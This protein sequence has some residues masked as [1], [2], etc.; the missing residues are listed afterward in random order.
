MQLKINSERGVFLNFANRSNR[1]SRLF[2]L[3]VL[4][5]FATRANAEVTLIDHDG[6]QKT[7]KQHSAESAAC[8]A[9]AL[10]TDPK[11]EGKVTIKFDVSDNGSVSAPHYESDKTTVKNS[12][13]ID[14][15]TDRLRGW[16]F[17]AAPAGSVMEVSLP[18]AVPGDVPI[19]SVAPLASP[20]PTGSSPTS[21][22]W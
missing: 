19:P 17:P 3:G 11:I 10:K 7:V 9:E 22:S 15:L 14:C 1:I 20:S 13:L 12:A 2:A 5:G 8:I 16:K 18:F 21:S 4:V 6:I